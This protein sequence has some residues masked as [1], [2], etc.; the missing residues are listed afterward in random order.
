MYD[1]AQMG[2]LIDRIIDDCKDQHIDTKPPEEIEALVK[3]WGVK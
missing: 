1:T 3:A 2:R